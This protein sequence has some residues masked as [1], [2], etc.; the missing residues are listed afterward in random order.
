MKNVSFDKFDSL[1]SES[2]QKL[3]FKNDLFHLSSAEIWGIFPKD[4]ALVCVPKMIP[5]WRIHFSNNFW[6]SMR[7]LKCSLLGSETVVGFSWPIPEPTAPQEESEL[8]LT[9]KCAMFSTQKRFYMFSDIITLYTKQNFSSPFTLP[10]H[11]VFFASF[12]MPVNFLENMQ[13]HLK[14]DES[15]MEIRKSFLIY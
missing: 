12:F 7:T 11:S 13:K 4:L 15:E 14:G 8:V 6:H 1:L 10:K 3:N 9:Q 2:A 5:L